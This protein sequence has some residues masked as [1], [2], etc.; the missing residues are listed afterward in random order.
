MPSPGTLMPK[1]DRPV[2]L[3]GGGEAHLVGVSGLHEFC[4][5]LA[6]GTDD[7]GLVTYALSMASSRN[8]FRIIPASVAS[9]MPR[10]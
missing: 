3:S 7:E 9:E 2:S 5:P 6:Q 8:L 10:A 4:P 1:C